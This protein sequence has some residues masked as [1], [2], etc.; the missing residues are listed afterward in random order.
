MVFFD[1][2]GPESIIC[3]WGSDDS[4]S[5]MFQYR[6]HL[7]YAFIY[8]SQGPEMMDCANHVCLAREQYEMVLGLIKVGRSCKN[9]N[10]LDSYLF[11]NTADDAFI[12]NNSE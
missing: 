8:T 6:H 11:G 10:K 5:P 9:F 1:I 3:L 12:G 7:K 2:L 4:S